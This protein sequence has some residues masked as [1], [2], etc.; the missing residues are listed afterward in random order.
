MTE[1]MVTSRHVGF[2]S[3]GSPCVSLSSACHRVYSTWVS[4]F[5]TTRRKTRSCSGFLRALLL[6]DK[7]FNGVLFYFA[8]ATAIIVFV[9]IVGLLMYA[10]L[11]ST[12]KASSSASFRSSFSPSSST[13]TVAVWVCTS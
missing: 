1:G 9:P 4:A 8:V 11:A 3:R 5:L 13:C 12:L 2:Q 7:L 10:A 6:F